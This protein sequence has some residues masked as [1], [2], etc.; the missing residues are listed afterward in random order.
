MKRYSSRLAS[1]PHD[2]VGVETGPGRR[3]EAGLTLLEVVATLAIT[4]IAFASM[5]LTAGTA[6]LGKLLTSTTI[7][8]EQQG[9]QVVEWI[10]DRVRQAGFGLGGSSIP[11]C[12]DKIATQSGYLPTTSQLWINGDVDNDGTPE[13]FGFQVETVSGV[14]TVTETVINCATGATALD[15]P[16]TSPT[17]IKVL[18]LT[19]GYYD[20]S[21]NAVTNL[22]S[23]VSIRTIRFVTITVQVQANGGA[24]GP[25]TQ[26]WSTSIDL[27]NP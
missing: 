22:A 6:I 20:S 8:K 4:V 7:A 14:P 26:T 9:R 12:Q 27:R 3:T 17:T 11:R 24:R 25:T 2:P 13:T 23:A 5:H 15:Q 19:F 10:A 21:G 1:I 16:I 18:A